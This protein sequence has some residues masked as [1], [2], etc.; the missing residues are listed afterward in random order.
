[1]IGGIRICLYYTLY[2]FETRL[3]AF[4][5]KHINAMSVIQDITTK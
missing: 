2:A 5:L 4:V 1:M 3:A